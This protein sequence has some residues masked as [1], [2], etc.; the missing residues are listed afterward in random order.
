MGVLQPWLLALG[1]G[2]A[3]PLLLHLFQR[4]QGP[5]VVF[6]ALRYL[7]RAERESARRV[8]VRQWL[9]LLLRSLAVLLIAL[10]AAR[11]FLQGAGGMHEPTAVVLVLDNSMSTSAVVGDRRVIDNLRDRALESL[12]RAGPDDRF[13]LVRTATPEEPATSGSAVAMATRVR[14][15][16]P[17][18]A[19]GDLAG[20]LARARVILAAGAEQRA[21]EIH[22]LSDLQA[23]ELQALG[24]ENGAPPLLVWTESEDPPPN[25]AISEVRVSGGLAPLAGQR[26]QVTAQVQGA[27]TD[28]LTLRLFVHGRLAAAATSPPDAAVALQLPG[29]GAGVVQGRVESDPDALAADDRRYFVTRVLPAPLVA[30]PGASPFLAEALGVMAAADRIRQG[31]EAAADVVMLSGGAA[32][33]LAPG[34]TLVVLPPVAEVELPALNQ[35][36]RRAGI[37][38]SY[39]TAGARGEAR[40]MAPD[41]TDPLLGTLARVRLRRIYPLLPGSAGTA[42]SV[43]LRLEDGSAWAVRGVSAGGTRYVLLG[44]PLDPEAS[45]IPTSAAMIPL[46]ERILAHWAVGRPER[47]EAT[48]GEEVTMPAGATRVLRPDSVTE[49]VSPGP[50]QV[51][52]LAGTYEVWSADSL[53]SAFAV[54]PPVRESDLRRANASELGEVFAN[55][56]VRS[57]QE[58]GQ[59]GRLVFRARLGLELWRPVLFILLALLLA[60]GLVAATGARRRTAG[61]DTRAMATD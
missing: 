36:L 23:T 2:V 34:A 6:P 27:R 59:W 45:S 21:P 55:W 48:T 19:A 32:L 13:W 28:S 35:Q 41:S 33:R 25:S 12:A 26:I 9:L 22:L 20:A 29:Q 40:L 31:G 18:P 61:T 49:A 16:E 43:L 39:G 53:V 47:L 38:W 7:R 5:R 15:T 1:I 30:A 17:V 50:Y 44:S 24:G 57:A 11:P 52:P 46:L 42:D 4:H 14:A 56:D 10:A 37:P 60:E 51:P 54:N 8:K 58:P 3:V